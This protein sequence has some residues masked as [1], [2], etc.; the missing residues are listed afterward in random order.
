MSLFGGP[1]FDTAEDEGNDLDNDALLS[2]ID[3]AL[4]P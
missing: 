4:L 3:D 1:E 2:M